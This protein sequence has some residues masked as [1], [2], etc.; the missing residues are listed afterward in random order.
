[1]ILLSLSYLFAGLGLLLSTAWASIP[2]SYPFD[3]PTFGTAKCDDSLPNKPPENPQLREDARK[4]LAAMG[5]ANPQRISPLLTLNLFRAIPIDNTAP[6]SGRPTNAESPTMLF[7]YW[8]SPL[9]Y[10]VYASKRTAN[11]V[12]KGGASIKT[13][14][15]TAVYDVLSTCCQYGNAGVQFVQT[16]EDPHGY[17][18]VY[19]LHSPNRPSG[20]PLATSSPPELETNPTPRGRSR[21]SYAILRT[22]SEGAELS[23]PKPFPDSPNQSTSAV[24]DEGGLTP[25]AEDLMSTAMSQFP[26]GSVPPGVTGGNNTQGGSNDYVVNI[27]ALERLVNEMRDMR[28]DFRDALLGSGVCTPAIPQAISRSSAQ[29]QQQNRRQDTN[30]CISCLAL[31]PRFMACARIDET[32]LEAMNRHGEEMAGCLNLCVGIAVPIGVCATL[33]G[34]GAT[35]WIAAHT[36]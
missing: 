30:R 14:I 23:Q 7:Q 27:S 2:T 21:G 22:S 8:E 15:A 24:E 13:K 9:L 4:K 32:C 25:V 34:A 6:S 3:K 16:S 17:I 1:M 26:E 10:E 5:S 11:L 28:R 12:D 33:A 19:V 18:E 35:L 29:V 20:D 31:I 36:P